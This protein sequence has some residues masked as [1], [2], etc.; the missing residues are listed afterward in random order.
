M[1]TKG[2]VNEFEVVMAT[3]N[4]DISEVAWTMWLYWV[5]MLGLA[6]GGI[7]AQLEDRKK[8]LEAYQYKFRSDYAQLESYRSMREGIARLKGQREYEDYSGLD[9]SNDL[10][11]QE[12]DSA[13]I[14]H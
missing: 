12:E 14:A 2:Y 3:N 1:Y 8:H 10:D 5:L 11:G 13:F 7:K 9:A 4:G 6:F